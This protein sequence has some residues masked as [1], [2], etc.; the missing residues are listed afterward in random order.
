MTELL[1]AYN[2]LVVRV[3]L[4]VLVLGPPV[5]YYVYDDSKKRGLSRPRLRGFAYGVLGILGLFVYM[6]RK[7]RSGSTH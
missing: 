6:A 1:T 3:A 4:Y 5:G 7:A 2:G